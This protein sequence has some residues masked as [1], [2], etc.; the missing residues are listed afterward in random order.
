MTPLAMDG[1]APK[2][3]TKIMAL[4]VTPYKIMASGNQAMDGMVCI[5]VIM[6]PMA[7]RTMVLRA[8]STP[9]AN[10]TKTAKAKPT[11]ARR[12]VVATADHKS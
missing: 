2:T 5:A 11:T 3:M 4:S 9:N 10:P 8:T 1:A 7:D 6:E 12:M